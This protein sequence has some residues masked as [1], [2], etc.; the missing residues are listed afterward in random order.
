M[1]YLARGRPGRSSGRAACGAQ[2][3]PRRRSHRPAPVGQD[4]PGAA[5]RPRRLDQPLRPRGSDKPRAPARADDDTGAAP[6]TVVID[7]GIGDT[8][9]LIR[10]GRGRR[11]RAAGWLAPREPRRAH[12]RSP[13]RGSHQRR[14][15]AGGRGAVKTRLQGQSPT[16][17]LGGLL[18]GGGGSGQVGRRRGRPRRA[19]RV[20]QTQVREDLA[21][22]GRVLATVAMSRSRRPQRGQAR[23][24]RSNT[25]RIRA[26]QVPAPR[27]PAARGLASRSRAWTSSGAGR[28]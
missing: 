5:D 15:C 25:R 1:V 27:V 28:P 19:R 10:P 17:R 20:E 4:D 11:G 12:Q 3:Q 9:A 2:A 13:S 7:E 24:S 6:G 23:T 21:H 16:P 18:M 26:A 8:K 22:H 14:W